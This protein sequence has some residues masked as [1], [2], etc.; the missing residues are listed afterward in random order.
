MR[1]VEDIEVQ[2][3]NA[4]GHELA[5]LLVPGHDEEFWGWVSHYP[6]AEKAKGFLLG[7]SAA[8]HLEPPPG[9]DDVSEDDEVD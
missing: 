4:G 6:E 3:W 1:A 8:A 9:Q 2:P 5:H 7:W